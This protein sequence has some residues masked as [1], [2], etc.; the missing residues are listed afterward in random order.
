M[1]EDSFGGWR[2][3]HKIKGQESKVEKNSFILTFEYFNS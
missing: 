1:P 2:N 3:L